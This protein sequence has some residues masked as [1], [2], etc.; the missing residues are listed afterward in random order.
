MLEVARASGSDNRDS[1]RRCD[2]PRQLEVVTFLCSIGVHAGQQNLPGANPGNTFGPLD[3]VEIGPIPAAVRVD[4]RG[5]VLATRVD[6]HDNALAAETLRC[7]ANKLRM[8][9]GRGI[10]RNFIGTGEQKVPDVVD[11]PHSSAD[12]QRHKALL[13]GGLYDTKKYAA[14]FVAC[15]DIEKAKFIGSSCVVGP[16]DLDW[17]ASV[18]QAGKTHAL[19]NPAVLDV[20]T[21]N[22]SGLQHRSSPFAAAISRSA[23]T[24]SRRPS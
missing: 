21:R 16:C 22:D 19:H 3:R 15:A 11:R 17:I 24:A 1:D 20:E 9:N 13:G 5:S 4:L 18:A 2:F 6:S 14:V 8:V 23:C 10:N 12:G 7:L